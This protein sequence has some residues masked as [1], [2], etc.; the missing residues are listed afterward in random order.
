MIL[1]KLVLGHCTKENS[2][3][4]S[5][6]IVENLNLWGQYKNEAPIKPILKKR[7]KQIVNMILKLLDP[8][9]KF[10]G[11]QL[12]KA[13]VC[14]W[15]N[16]KMCLCFPKKFS[17][18]WWFYVLLIRWVLSNKSQVYSVIHTTTFCLYAKFTAISKKATKCL[19]C[20]WL[21]FLHQEFTLTDTLHLQTTSFQWLR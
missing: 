15:L 9:N 18:W 6:K 4:N 17:C 19:K 13:F 1:V 2:I 10:L 8:V 5:F 14:Y 11:E 12:R 3:A 7:W 21:K 16:V 20:P